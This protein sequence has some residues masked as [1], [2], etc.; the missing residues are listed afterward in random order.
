MDRGLIVGLLLAFV[1][2]QPGW[3]VTALFGLLLVATGFSSRARDSSIAGANWTLVQVSDA[4]AGVTNLVASILLGRS[5]DRR[6]PC[7]DELMANKFSE[8]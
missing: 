4:D 3:E 8:A 1:G 5:V 2:Y 7:F 6:G